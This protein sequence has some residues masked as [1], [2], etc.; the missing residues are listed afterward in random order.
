LSLEGFLNR[1]VERIAELSNTN[2]FSCYQCGNC[3][4]GCPAADYMDLLPHQVIRLIQLGHIEEILDSNTPW[5][6]AACITCSV[7]CPKG[8]DIAA[9]MEAL[10]Q[11]VLRKNLQRV[12]INKI[13]RKDLAEL[14][15]IALLNYFRKLTL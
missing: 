5:I 13:D 14:P 15:Q 10:R 7:R 4:G 2:I 6:C 3:S 1:D 12:D 9:V 11:L 8:V